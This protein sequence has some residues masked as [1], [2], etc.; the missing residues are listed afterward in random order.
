MNGKQLMGKELK[1]EFARGQS[2]RD[3]GDRG[4]FRGDRGGRGR[5]G[6]DRRRDDRPK[7]CFNCGEEGHFARDCSKRMIK[8]IFST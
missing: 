5:G 1:V 3:R 6:D 2:N 7:G 4:G 8:F